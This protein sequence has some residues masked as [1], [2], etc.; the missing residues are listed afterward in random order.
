MRR[1]LSG[2]NPHGG[3]QGDREAEG[4]GGA[5][6][7]REAG[8]RRGH[9]HRGEAG[10]GKRQG[11]HLG[12]AREKLRPLGDRPEPQA[13]GSRLLERARGG[14]QHPGH[15][16]GAR[17][18]VPCA[19]E[20]LKRSR[21][22]PEGSREESREGR[23]TESH[24]QPPRSLGGEEDVGQDEDDVVTP[25]REKEVQ[26]VGWIEDLR[27]G[28]GEQGLAERHGA[29]PK[30]PGGG[31]D[32]AHE[33]LGLGKEVH[34]Q[35]TVVEDLAEQEHPG[36]RASRRGTKARAAHRPRPRGKGITMRSSC[37][38]S[39]DV[40]SGEAARVSTTPGGPGPARRKKGYSLSCRG[41]AAT[42]SA[43]RRTL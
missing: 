14:E 3:G 16:G 33:R 11:G 9:A 1:Q 34:V 19:H 30:G 17:E 37:S 36:K 27:A 38:P 25:G 24:P 39:G 22:R 21:S 8:G 15:P 4:L 29:V 41:A 35:V 6:K 43:D 12:G 10:E 23:E 20:G 31:E 32:G 28:V 26:P 2:G 5:T 18:V 7:A 13:T 42:A 40:T